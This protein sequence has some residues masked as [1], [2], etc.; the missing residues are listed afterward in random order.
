MRKVI[1][2]LP[3]YACYGI[4]LAA[5]SLV[6]LKA[7]MDEPPRWWHW[8]YRIYNWGMVRS[9]IINDWAGFTLWRR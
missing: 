8:C 1:A 3:M 2:W 7:H 5:F 4:G 9:S 6:D